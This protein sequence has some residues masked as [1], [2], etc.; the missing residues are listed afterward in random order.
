MLCAEKNK[1]NASI[2]GEVGVGKCWERN[3]FLIVLL[4]EAQKEGRAATWPPGCVT[5]PT[6]LCWKELFAHHRCPGMHLKD[7]PS[8]GERS[9]SR[10][11]LDSFLNSCL[12]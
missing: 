6:I 2:Q 11:A 1:W 10:I 7:V 9:K 4:A 12:M 3:T 8:Q 5:W